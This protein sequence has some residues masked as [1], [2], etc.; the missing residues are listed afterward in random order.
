MTEFKKDILYFTDLLRCGD[1]TDLSIRL[2]P[3]GYFFEID[4]GEEIFR[5]DCVTEERVF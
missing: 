3:L 2:S 5:Y 4:T 1:L